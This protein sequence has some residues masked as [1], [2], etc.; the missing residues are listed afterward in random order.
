MS[1]FAPEPPHNHGAPIST[2]VLLI[3]L[4]TP[5]AP[6][7]Q[8]VRAYLKQFLSDPR[9]VEIPRA[10]LAADPDLFV[11][12]AAAQGIGR[13]LRADLDARR[14]AAQ[15]A[16]RAAGDSP[17]RLSGRAPARA[18]RRRLRDALRLAFD[19]GKARGDESAGLRADPA[20]SAL[21]AVFGE[22][23]GDR[24]RCSLPR[25]RAHAQPARDP[26]RETFSRRSRLHR[27]ARSERAGSLDASAGGP[28]CSS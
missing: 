23:H 2:G 4:G 6:T 8:A 18:A 3:N 28:T 16:H 17:A 11:L 5:E 10:R 7:P 1:R 15:G 13:A 14:L 27:G 19:R 25:A 26:H 22:H 20:R 9:V 24:V 12:T 21:P